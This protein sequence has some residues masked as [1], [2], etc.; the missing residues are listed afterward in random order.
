MSCFHKQCQSQVH[1]LVHL[2]GFLLLD[3]IMYDQ[4]VV[5]SLICLNVHMHAIAVAYMLTAHACTDSRCHAIEERQ[6]EAGRASR[7][8]AGCGEPQEL[9]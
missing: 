6:P 5:T 1:D 2:Y 3:R 8:H 4:N 7:D 9:V